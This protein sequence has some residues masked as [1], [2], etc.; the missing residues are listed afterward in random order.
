MVNII[1]M[2]KSFI[3]F[4]GLIPTTP[5]N[6]KCYKCGYVFNK[7]KSMN[8]HRLCIDKFYSLGNKRQR[9]IIDRYSRDPSMCYVCNK[10]IQAGIIRR[11][12]MKC[13]QCNCLYRFKII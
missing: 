3:S 2:Y 8:M 9:R 7:K 4:L 5:E 10:P 11:I 13:P 12:G 1:K 6:P